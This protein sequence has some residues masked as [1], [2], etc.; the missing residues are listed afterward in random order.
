MSEN[1]NGKFK[2]LFKI[3]YSN[4]S[5]TFKMIHFVKRKTKKGKKENLVHTLKI[6]QINEM[7]EKSMKTY[8]RKKL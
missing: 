3:I 7:K 6:K 5:L 4:I 8:I 2:K 1:A